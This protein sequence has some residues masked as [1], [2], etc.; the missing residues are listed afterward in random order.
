M[1][2]ISLEA[3]V[4]T[5]KVNTGY[6]N[7]IQ[8][9]RFLNSNNLLCPTWNERDLTGRKVCAD[10]FWTK[11]AGCNSATD[12]ISVENYQRPQYAEYITL[13]A[14]GIQGNMYGDPGVAVENFVDLHRRDE[15]LEYEALN[16]VHNITGQFG[17]VT[18]FR[19][20]IEANCAPGYETAM[21]A[22]AQ[23]N[24]QRQAEMYGNIQQARRMQMRSGY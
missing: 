15:E 5:C 24:R 12:R 9:D 13:D 10:S 6:A 16:N 23:E 4:R 20:N 2:N 3:S 8:S 11:R 21:A 7:K 17:M 14:N 19:Q 1:S 22:V 18:G